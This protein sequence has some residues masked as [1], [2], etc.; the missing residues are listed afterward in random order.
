MNNIL[1]IEDDLRMK[2]LISEILISEG[3]AVTSFCDPRDAL[4]KLESAG[5]DIVVTDLKMPHMDGIEVLEFCKTKFPEMPVIL[6]TAHGTIESAI[7][8]IKKGA[9]DFIQKPFD[10]DQLVLVIKRASKIVELLNKNR[11]L[12][13]MIT[14]LAEDD[15]IGDNENLKNIKATIKKVAELDVTVLIQ[16]ETGTGKELVA[17]L[18]QKNSRRK[19]S[20]FLSVNCGA[21]AENLLESELFGHEKGAFTGAAN[22]RKGLFETASGG[23][24]FLD[25]INSTSLA[26]QVKLLR[27]LQENKILRVGSSKPVNIDIRTIVAS[28]KNLSEEIE[29][30][31]FRKDLFYRIN[32]ININIPPLRERIED[33][34]KLAYYF[35]KKCSG[36]YGK[37]IN[38]FDIEVLNILKKHEWPGNIREL[39]NVI[40]SS[41][42]MEET[43]RITL[44]SVPEYIRS[45]GVTVRDSFGL[46]SLEEMEKFM[47]KRTLANFENKTRAAESLGIDPATLWRKIKKYN[48]E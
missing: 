35:L 16:G 25:E 28:N 40:E 17:K 15:L 41:F 39:E 48:L 14:D 9:Y 34:P 32:M 4:I 26:F 12:Q 42:I 3:F 46:M 19:N 11:E 43:D 5:F 31:A 21:I 8:A 44:K 18:I 2:E 36:K 33:V 45:K 7:D 37:K 38:L 27:V 22:A 30:G 13:Q 24:I 29:K 20:T 10:P 1:A 23:T 6:I 47:I